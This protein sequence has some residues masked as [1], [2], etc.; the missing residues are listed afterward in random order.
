[1]D[2]RN[3]LKPDWRKILFFIIT[4]GGLNYWWIS[5]NQVCDDRLLF[6]LPFGFFPKGSIFGE[7]YPSLPIPKVEFSW[8]NFF[9]DIIFWYLLACIIYY[10]YDSIKHREKKKEGN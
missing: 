7:N 2:W 3:F 1:M 5:G 4:M 10:G 8:F 6:G 9:I